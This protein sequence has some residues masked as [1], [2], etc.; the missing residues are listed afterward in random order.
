MNILEAIFTFLGNTLPRFDWC[1]NIRYLFYRMAGMKVS[2]DVKFFG[3]ITV[4]PLGGIQNISIKKGTFLNTDT[5]FGCPQ[6]IINIGSNCQIGPRVSFETV[7]HELKYCE[8]HGRND[9]ILP[10][11]VKDEVW[12]G[13]GAIIL[14]GVTI[15]KGAVIASGAVVTKDV[16]PMTVVGGIPAKVIKTLDL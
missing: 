8:H 7:N 11:V 3:P 14:P 5:R 13:C 15:G 4:R 1:D 12:I 2:E 10:I 6:Q 9:I 16:L